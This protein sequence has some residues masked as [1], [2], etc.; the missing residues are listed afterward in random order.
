MVIIES[1]DERYLLYCIAYKYSVFVEVLLCNMWLDWA[2]LKITSVL[3]LSHT[4]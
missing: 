1:M 3:N 4:V 2:R